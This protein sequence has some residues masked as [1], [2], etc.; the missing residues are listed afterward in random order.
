M[1]ASSIASWATRAKSL[2][3]IWSSPRASRWALMIIRRYLLTE[4]PG[5]AT[6]Y[7]KAMKRPACER[8][9]GAASVMSSPLKVIEPS[10]TS[11]AG[12]PMITLARVDLPEPLGPI[13]ACT[14]PFS[15]SRSSPLRI[16]LSSTSTCR[17]RISSSAISLRFWGFLK[18]LSSAADGG[19]ALLCAVV[20][21]LDQLGQGGPGQRLGDAALDSHPEQLRRTGLVAVG[22]VRTEDFPF[23]RVVEALHRRDLSF[24]CLDHRVHRDLLGGLRQ[25]VAAVGAAGGGD[26]AGLAQFRYQVLQ[27]GERQVLR[28]GDGAQRGR[29]RAG[30]AAQLDHQANSVLGFGR[31]QHRLQ[32]LLKRSVMRLRAK[33]A[34]LWLDQAAADRVADELDPV[35]HPELAHRV[36]AVILDRLLGEVEDLGDLLGRVRLGDKLDD[37][38]LARGQ[39]LF[40]A[41]AALEHVLDQR[42]LRLGGEERLAPL[43]RP[44][45]RQE[46]GVC[47]CLQHVAGG[48]GFQRL[49]QVALVVVHREDQD[50]DLRC[51]LLDLPRRL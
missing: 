42:P 33:R 4:T 21:E 44:D 39:L 18:F 47:L 40:A 16:F 34:L 3:L 35:A 5:I 7:W 2:I 20:G 29:L 11:K 41:G 22:L 13:S 12:W 1:F 38:L 14:F 48:A 24:Q 28:F 36:G 15:T 43:D 37:L 32:I 26:E 6:G 45:R 27:V 9:S 25:A 50:R 17:F 31:E 8:S 30:L 19:D 10:V 51:L 46:I 49:E 23:G